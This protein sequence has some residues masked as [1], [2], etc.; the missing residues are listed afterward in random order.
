MIRTKQVLKS[1]KILF[2]L[3][4][5]TIYIIYIIYSAPKYAHIHKYIY[6]YIIYIYIHTPECICLH[7]YA[8]FTVLN[9]TK[10]I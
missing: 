1:Y 8:V 4:M 5:Y 7:I 2:T 10:I 9:A 3:H 6:I